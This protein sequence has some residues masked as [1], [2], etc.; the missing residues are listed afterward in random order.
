MFGVFKRFKEILP[1]QLWGPGIVIAL[2]TFFALRETAGLSE[3]I[4]E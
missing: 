4:P 3:I 1:T 2:S